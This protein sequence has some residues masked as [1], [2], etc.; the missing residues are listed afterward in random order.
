MHANGNR[1]EKHN[2]VF[3]QYEIHVLKYLEQSS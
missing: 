2:K 3:Y 1:F